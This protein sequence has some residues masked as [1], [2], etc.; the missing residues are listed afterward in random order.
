M[1]T[2]T[3]IFQSKA[4]RYIPAYGLLF[5]L[6]S[7]FSISGVK[8][9]NI[10]EVNQFLGS[11]ESLDLAIDRNYLYGNHPTAY[12]TSSRANLPNGNSPKKV[13][14][15]QNSFERIARLS[16]ELE[17]VEI[18]RVKLV[19]EIEKSGSI[20]ASVLDYMPSLKVILIVSEVPISLV[21]VQNMV[22]QI[23][24]P[25]VKILYIYSQPA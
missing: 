22:S 19:S 23:Q 11:Q 12:V 6:L 25:G 14:V 10:S 13:D 3:S 7:S 24:N 15:S 18:L 17:T 8:A 2:Y 5:L 16:S 9:Q 4:A 21:E 20:P 1:N